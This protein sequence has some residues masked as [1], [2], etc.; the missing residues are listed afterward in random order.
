MSGFE[1]VRLPGEGVPLL[2]LHG[3]GG[4]EH[5]LL[6]L[7]EHL[8]P[9][10]PVLAPR[11]RVTENGMNRFFRR[12]AEG[13]LDEDDLRFRVDEL[14][15]F[16]VGVDPG[17]WVAAGFSNGANTASALLFRRPEVLSGAVLLAAMVP[18]RDGPV[19]RDGGEVDLSGKRVAVSNGRHDPLVSATETATLVAQLRG[20]G[21]TV[22]EFPHGG[23]HGIDADV[24]PH[25]RAFLGR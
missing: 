2:L 14:A 6:P 10:S 17:P 5:D 18:F 20:C 21:A 16:V 19:A 22:E 7:R 24:L 4:T 15:D 25:V 23:G 1:H 11:G 12:L 8:A 13:V 9:G 3:T